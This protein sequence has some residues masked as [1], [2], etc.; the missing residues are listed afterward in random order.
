M[1]RRA[2]VALLAWALLPLAA[3]AQDT[4]TN[5]SVVA[6]VKAG[7]AESVII[8]RIQSGAAT[9]DTDADALSALRAAGVPE[10]IIQAMVVAPPPGVA[11]HGPLSGTPT[12]RR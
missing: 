3:G 10:R 1:I 6:L 5:Q 11:G 8:A 7:V 9:F 4:L 2:G 12:P